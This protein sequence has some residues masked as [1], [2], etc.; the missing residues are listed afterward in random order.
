MNSQAGESWYREAYEQL[1]IPYQLLDPRGHLVTVN[2]VWLQMLGYSAS[3]VEDRWLGDFLTSESHD[4]FTD[5]LA[6]I[7]DEGAAHDVRLHL[8]RKDGTIVSADYSGRAAWDESGRFTR[9]HGCLQVATTSALPP[10]LVDA[11]N[12]DQSY[13]L[14]STGE[15]FAYYDTQL[16]IQWANKAAAASAGLPLKDLL[17]RH[18]YEIWHGRNAPCDDC[19]V[20]EAMRTGQSQDGET[21]TPD[22]RTFLLRSYPVF[23]EQGTVVG[24]TEFGQDITERKQAADALRRSEL[25]HRTTIDAL[26]DMIHVVGPDMKLTLVNASFACWCRRLG[27]DG[28][29]L[30][31]TVFEMF[32]FLPPHVREEYTHVFETGA[33]L[34]TEETTTIGGEQIVTETHKAPVLEDGKVTQ[35]V[36]VV[37]DI[38]NRRRA[39]E[40]AQRH[41]D[42]LAHVA[43]VNT[44][45]EMASA[46]S[47]E[48]SQPLAAIAAYTQGCIRRLRSAQGDPH[49]MIEPMEQVTKQAQRAGEIIRR[50]RAF[51]RRTDPHR[52][53]VDI[54]ELVREGAALDEAD[55]R[56]A[57][58]SLHFDLTP[59]LPLV[60]ADPVEI[61]QVV[62]NLL[63]NGIEAMDATE[64]GHRRLV[65]QTSRSADKHI[66]V[67]VADTGRGLPPTLQDRIFE[68]FVTTK[69]R[70]MGMGLSISRS[71]IEAHGGRLWVTPNAE[72]GVTFHFSLP[73]TQSSR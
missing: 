71:I 24:L 4:R 53:T 3:E 28:E 73:I 38:T 49:E 58:V 39:E 34:V 31:R 15:L 68:P 42:E 12:A 32:P 52:S 66:E 25:Q 33:S 43:R 35:V 17:G 59:D 9:A 55:V 36:T 64:P 7:K 29:P 44:M 56:Q 2:D 65:L 46:L 1:P 67:A 21:T 62:L 60:L 5:A 27:I 18:C 47:H 69:P 22:G 48:L 26:G 57:N 16:R 63:R 11:A 51:V 50:L 14:A 45:G 70:G 37:R 23:D 19:P 54:N 61:E 6:R 10:E 40:A 20:L 13:I 72:R 8:V 41:L 30:G